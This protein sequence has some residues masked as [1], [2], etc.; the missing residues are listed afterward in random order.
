MATH[1]AEHLASTDR[2]V[3]LLRRNIRN[4]IRTVQGG[5]DPPR[6]PI[7]GGEVN[8]Y[9]QDTVLPFAPRPP[10]EDESLMKALTAAVMDV[11]RRGD[12]LAGAARREFIERNLRDLTRDPRFGAG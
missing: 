5:G 9:V 7:V 2:G 8:T 11:V 10:E 3:A 1:G 6:L 12:E 4:G